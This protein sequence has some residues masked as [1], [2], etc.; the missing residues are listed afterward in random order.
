MEDSLKIALEDKKSQIQKF[1]TTLET[2]RRSL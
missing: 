2:I 1:K